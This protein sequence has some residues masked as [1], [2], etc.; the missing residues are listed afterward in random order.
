MNPIDVVALA[1][2][3]LGILFGY[4]RGFIQSVLNLGGGLLSFWGA[5]AI[6]PKIA[7]LVSGNPDIIRFI[8]TYTD[9]ANFLGDLDVSEMVVSS[10]QA[11]DITSIV[12]NAP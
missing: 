3:F 9:S 4:Y 8:S 11:S 5:F 10:L 1:I 2:L 6:Y 12:Q 7:N